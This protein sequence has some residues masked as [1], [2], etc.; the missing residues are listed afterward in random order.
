MQRYLLLIMSL[1]L[2]CLS[3]AADHVTMAVG[4]YTDSGSRGIYSLR[5]DQKSGKAVVLDSMQ[6]S[7]PSFLTFSSDGRFIYAVSEN[8]GNDASLH[9]VSFA[10]SSGMMTPVNSVPTLGADPC[11]VETNGRV[12]L[13]ANYTGGSMSVFPI[14][15][16]GSL[17]N[18][19]HVFSRTTGGKHPQQASAHVHTAR[20]FGKGHIL[21]TD[22]SADRIQLY[23]VSDTT[24]TPLGTAGFTLPHSAPRHLEFSKDRRHVYA[25]NELAGTVTV[26]RAEGPS[27]ER[28]QTV[29][30]D[31][32]G[33]RGCADIH[34][35]KDGRF[36]YASN[37]LKADGISIFAVD[38]ANGTLKKT[39]Y[40]NTGLHPRN[41][42]ITPNGRFLLCACR[43]SD[44]IQVFRIDRRT[45]ML[46]D[47]HN[48]IR[49]K[50]PVCVQFCPSV[51]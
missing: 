3:W 32:A 4:T 16:D 41:F 33:G 15:S 12:A 45:G 19:L 23:S 40:V 7:N 2:H 13:T 18:A 5:F 36:L 11:Y 22:F 21:S 46:T 24:V 37:R 44:V 35:S 31:S 10:P 17:G 48:D 34:L 26:F 20:F 43:D 29:V 6:M 28:I 27:L 49:M 1:S 38:R 8:G 30:S 50:K 25:I 42:A 14:H 51:R 39:G 47:T 9:A